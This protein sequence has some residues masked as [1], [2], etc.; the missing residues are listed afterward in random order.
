MI[1]P[2]CASCGGKKRRANGVMIDPTEHQGV[3]IFCGQTAQVTLWE[4][5]LTGFRP[6]YH[7]CRYCG[8]EMVSLCQYSN[9]IKGCCSDECL[10]KHIRKK[11][12]LSTVGNSRKA[13]EMNRGATCF[14]NSVPCRRYADTWLGDAGWC[15]CSGYVASEPKPISTRQAIPAPLLG[16]RVNITSG[17][18]RNN[19]Y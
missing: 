6:I 9:N 12:K 8:K 19:S 2:V 17:G 7:K 1:K 10:Q 15:D 11:G 4:V 14:R 3:C 18:R 16:L 13:I 5:D